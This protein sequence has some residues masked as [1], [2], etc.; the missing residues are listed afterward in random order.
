M[1]LL[2]SVLAVCLAGVPLARAQEESGRLRVLYRVDP[3]QTVVDSRVVRP[4]DRRTMP[5]SLAD[6]LRDHEVVM[7]YLCWPPSKETVSPA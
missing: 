1:R 3:R 4:R 5:D 6:G 7:L 2:S